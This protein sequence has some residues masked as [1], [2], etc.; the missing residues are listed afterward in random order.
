MIAPATTTTSV[1]PIISRLR[2]RSVTEILDQAFRLYRKHFLTFL[3]IMAVTYVPVQLLVQAA[4]LFVLGSAAELEDVTNSSRIDGGQMNEYLVAL[5]V[6][7]GA[8]MLFALLSSL[9]LYL[10]QGALTS[11]VISSHMDRPVSF[12]GA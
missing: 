12:G 9:L 8:V 10:S 1:D 6:G 7:V 5:F 3:A 11:A 2:P 4:S